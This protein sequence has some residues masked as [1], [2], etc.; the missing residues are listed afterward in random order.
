M[1]EGVGTIVAGDLSSI[2]EDE[3]SGESRN[4]GKHGNLDHI[5]PVNPR[6]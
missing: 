5:A 6:E 4:W 2:R 1:D 3:E